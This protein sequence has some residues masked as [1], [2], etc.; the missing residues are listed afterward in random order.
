MNDTK[1][2][3]N[4]HTIYHICLHGIISVFL[5][6]GT[7]TAQITIHRRAIDGIL[8]LQLFLLFVC[9]LCI[10]SGESVSSGVF[11]LICI[12]FNTNLW[13]HSSLQFTDISNQNLLVIPV[14]QSPTVSIKLERNSFKF[15][16][17]NWCVLSVLI[18]CVNLV[19]EK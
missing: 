5:I 4:S 8:F 14:F 1:N 9:L 15:R 13:P 6:F 12:I 11:V 19:C 16:Q 10:G 17:L 2:N 3:I 18:K 7:D